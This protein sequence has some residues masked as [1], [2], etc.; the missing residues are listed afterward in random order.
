MWSDVLNGGTL[1]SDNRAHDPT[2][3]GVD[4]PKTRAEANDVKTPKGECVP[5]YRFVRHHLAMLRR[6]LF[7]GDCP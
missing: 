2:E 1:P 6:L 4:K 7:I 5:V 3:S